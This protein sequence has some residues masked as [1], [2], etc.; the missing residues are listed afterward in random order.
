[1]FHKHTKS[2]LIKK[3]IEC[4]RSV[5]VLTAA[6]LALSLLMTVSGCTHTSPYTEPSFFQTLGQDS[7]MVM[8]MDVKKGRN[9]IDRTFSDQLQDSVRLVDKADR[10]SIA[11][12]TNNVTV[13]PSMYGG[14]EGDY[15][16]FWINTGLW[17][18]SDWKI[19]RKGVKYWEDPRSGIQLV[20]PKNGII[21]FSKGGMADVYDRSIENRVVY[22]PSEIIE[23]LEAASIALYAA[24]PDGMNLLA[25][26]LPL[27]FSFDFEEVWGTVNPAEEEAENAEMDQNICY[28]VDGEIVLLEK[29]QARVFERILKML[30]Q[31]YISKNQLDIVYNRESI[32]DADFSVVIDNL[33]IDEHILFSLIDLASRDVRQSKSNE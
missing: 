26:N 32:E 11:A 19:E 17:F 3:Q 16:K 8:T 28:T 10:V 22:V 12:K 2:R 23:K 29:V 9:V 25:S 20:S 21:L 18:S 5:H 15:S 33:K 13:S 6:V 14:I 4:S 31:D 24:H 30:Y 27:P 1:M 7:E